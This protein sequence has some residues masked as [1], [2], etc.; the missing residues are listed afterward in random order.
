MPRRACRAT[1]AWRTSACARPSAI[2]ADA[3]S[4]RVVGTADR[5]MERHEVV[6]NPAGH[7]LQVHPQ[8]RIDLAPGRAAAEPVT[9]LRDRLAGL[10]QSL[11]RILHVRL[12]A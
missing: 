1:S 4:R 6:V 7:I 9:V 5:P 3:R 10:L 12:A 2:G 11:A 8:R